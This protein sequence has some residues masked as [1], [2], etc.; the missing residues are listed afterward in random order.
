MAATS[1]C[2]AVKKCP[3][4]NTFMYANHVRSGS[5]RKRICFIIKIDKFSVIKEK[6][7]YTNPLPH[8]DW[9]L[10]I[11]K[12]RNSITLILQTFETDISEVMCRVRYSYDSVSEDIRVNKASDDNYVIRISSEI[13]NVPGNLSVLSTDCLF[14]ELHAVL[15]SVIKINRPVLENRIPSNEEPASVIYEHKDTEEGALIQ[16]LKV[17]LNFVDF[18][19]FKIK[20]KDSVR[21]VHKPIIAARSKFFF[22]YLKEN[23]DSKEIELDAS[24]EAFDRMYVYMYYGEICPTDVPTTIALMKLAMKLQM[25]KLYEISL[26][27]VMDSIYASNV[28]LIRQA[29]NDF[30]DNVLVSATDEFLSRTKRSSMRV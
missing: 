5:H 21:Y 11:S 23:P 10:N 27:F 8:K 26:N 12:N 9:M 19:N 28:Q 24:I 20:I 15:A 16:D 2:T 29:G 6:T 18:A 13:I 25:K 22:D 17:K 7:S 1:E 14:C 4:K 30:G 3:L